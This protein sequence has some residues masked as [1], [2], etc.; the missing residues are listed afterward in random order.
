M[1]N[2]LSRMTT[3]HDEI[4]R[5][6]E[7]RGAK[8]TE[9]ARTERHGE[10][11]MIRLDFPGY[12]G[13]GS[14][15]PISWDEWFE[16]FDESGLAL[17]YQ[18]RTAGGQR[19]NFNKLIGRETAEARA[20][21]ENKA[22]R[23][24]LRARGGGARRARSSTRGGTR[25]RRGES[26]RGRRTSRG[27]STRSSTRTRR[28]GARTGRQGGRTTTSRRTSARRQAPSA[29]AARLTGRARMPMGEGSRRGGS[30]RSSSRRGRGSSRSSTSRKGTRRT[31]RRSSSRS[32]SR[33]R[34]R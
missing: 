34:R 16:K 22:S 25:S 33:G 31:T 17:V 23:R 30:R 20:Q 27:A 11:G 32:G 26:R 13:A 3:D 9:V 4:R 15:K 28:T 2:R 7:E 14:L 18:D 1:A 8:P 29:I 24:S 12:S 10:T 19:S 5:W 6:A 21:G